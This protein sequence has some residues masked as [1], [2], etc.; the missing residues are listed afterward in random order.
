MT[1]FQERFRYRAVETAVYR[2]TPYQ[3]GGSD[4]IKPFISLILQSDDPAP[5]G[6]QPYGA[7][8][9]AV[10]LV[11]PA[12]LDE[13]YRSRWTYTWR[14]EPF[15]SIGL[16]ETGMLGGYYEGSNVKFADEHLRRVGAIE[17]DGNVP[18]DEVDDLTEHRED[19]LQAWQNRQ[20]T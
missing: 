8:E 12:E 11:D 10:Y 6:L 19:L 5:P 2:G 4:R 1:T 14:G 9:D 3:A 20:A 16:S 18:L 13:W 17:Y 7:P 15:T